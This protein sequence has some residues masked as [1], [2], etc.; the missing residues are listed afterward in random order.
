MGEKIKEQQTPLNFG[1]TR[2]DQY[3]SSVQHWHVTSLS[4]SQCAHLEKLYLLCL[5]NWVSMGTTSHKIVLSMIIC[6][7]NMYVTWLQTI[8]LCL[9]VPIYTTSYLFRNNRCLFVLSPPLASCLR[10]S[11]VQ[12]PLPLPESGQDLVSDWRSWL[13]STVWWWEAQP[14]HLI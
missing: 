3:P 11:L 5:L 1:V 4:E 8:R 9:Y 6:P 13:S 2:L 12:S 14:D 7:A 10:V